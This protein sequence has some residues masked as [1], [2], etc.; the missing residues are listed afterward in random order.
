MTNVYVDFSKEIGPIKPMHATNNGPVYKFSADQ[1]ITNIDA[2]RAAGIPYARNHDAAFDI[3]ELLP[4]YYPFYMFNK[5]YEQGTQVATESDGGVD[6]A[7][8]AA[9]GSFIFRKAFTFRIRCVKM[10]L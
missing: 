2:F 4:G 1:R 9:I 10:D 6:I 7:A 8:I 3:S 5:F